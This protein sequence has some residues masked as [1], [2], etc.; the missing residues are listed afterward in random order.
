M[1]S[2]RK[3]SCGLIKKPWSSLCRSHWHQHPRH[4][5][6]LSRLQQYD[7]EIRYKPGKGMLLP[8]SLL[9][10]VMKDCE[11]SLAGAVERIRANHILPVP[12][13]Q[14]NKTHGH[15]ER[16][17][18][19]WLYRGWKNNLGRLPD[20]KD[21]FPAAV[22]PSNCRQASSTSVS[23]PKQLRKT[24][25]TV[26][27]KTQYRSITPDKPQIVDARTTG[28]ERLSKPSSLLVG[29]FKSIIK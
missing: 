14:L 5:S 26:P 9:G 21:D 29:L 17:F 25:V 6:A 13:H 20:A 19:S 10:A 11:L 27:R 24:T 16:W 18:V 1:C 12:D 22:L 15:R 4:L 3:S 2:V 7:Y 8:G 28:S 23:R